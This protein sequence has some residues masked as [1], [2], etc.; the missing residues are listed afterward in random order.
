MT[1]PARPPTGAARRRVRI[2]DEETGRRMLDAAIGMITERGL[3]VSLEHLSLEEII[4]V[5]GVARSSVYRRWP[6]KDLFFSDLL[7]ELASAS[8]LA[9]GWGVVVPAMEE[10]LAGQLVRPT[11]VPPEQDRV[12]FFVEFLRVIG[13]VDLDQITGSP[14]WRTYFALHATHLG[15]PDGELRRHVGAA[16]ARSERQLTELRAAVLRRFAPVGGYRLIDRSDQAEGFRMLSMAVGASVTGLIVKSFADPVP[17][18][19]TR[20]LAPFGTSR[21]AEWTDAQLVQVHLFLSYLEPD[22]EVSWSGE[23]VQALARSVRDMA[24]EPPSEAT[25][26]GWA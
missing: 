26:I 18:R 7:V 16:L 12:D 21:P 11:D 13:A 4:K 5:A 20:R 25:R 8:T 6:Y 1:T 9:Q 15:L 17:T 23:R 3:S 10:F 2:S 22:P 14:E 24:T 19:T